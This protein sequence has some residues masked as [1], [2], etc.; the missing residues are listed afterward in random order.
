M[1]P[2]H[3]VLFSFLFCVAISCS[4]PAVTPAPCPADGR[5]V[6]VWYSAP[7][8]SSIHSTGAFVGWNEHWVSIELEDG[9][10]EHVSADLIYGIREFK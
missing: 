2:S 5:T 4:K 9:A 7:D 1:K 6:S 8:Q 10:V 3:L